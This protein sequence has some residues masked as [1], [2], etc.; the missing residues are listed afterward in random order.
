VM[1]AAADPDTAIEIDPSKRFSTNRLMWPGSIPHN[2]RFRRAI[3]AGGDV[4]HSGL[5]TEQRD[6]A[7]SPS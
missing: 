1:P 3:N 6:Y 5:A 4:A 2:E 7:T